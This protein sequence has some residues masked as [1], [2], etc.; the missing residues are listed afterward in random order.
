MA[1]H[2]SNSMVKA[3]LVASAMNRVA[4]YVNRPS[5]L[6]AK[7]HSGSLTLHHAKPSG[8][9]ARLTFPKV[10]EAR[11]I[12]VEQAIE[13]A[14][15]KPVEPPVLL[16]LRLEQVSDARL[17][18]NLWNGSSCESGRSR[19][20][21]GRQHQDDNGR[22]GHLHEGLARLFRLLPKARGADRSH[23]LGPVATAGR[24]LA[25]MENTTASPRGSCRK[26][27]LG[28][29]CKEH[30]RQR[31]WSM[32]SCPQQSPLHWA[33]QCVLQIARSPILVRRVLA[34]L[35]EPPCTD[36]YARWCGRGGPARRTL[37]KPRIAVSITSQLL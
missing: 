9:I 33:F 12:E 14:L 34:Q 1:C 22:T 8:L 37:A 16:A 17:R 35:L 24:S 29:G 28:M 25:P 26:W 3:R 15:E 18:R 5:R 4:R 23:S 27:G 21:Q 20:G 11:L 31:P 7:A 36:P 10:R 13:A 32:V 30:G 2:H 19:E 6:V